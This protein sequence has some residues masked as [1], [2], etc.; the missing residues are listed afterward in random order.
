MFVHLHFQCPKCPQII[1]FR[2]KREHL[3]K[4]FM[5]THPHCLGM[6]QIVIPLNTFELTI[7]AFSADSPFGD[8]TDAYNNVFDFFRGKK[9]E[10][11]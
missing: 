5:L 11:D 9:D 7:S 3:G 10:K 2:V 4:T 1:G 6:L 8:I